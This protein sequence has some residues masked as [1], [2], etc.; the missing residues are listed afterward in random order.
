MS[1]VTPCRL[2]H[3]VGYC[4]LAWKYPCT[5][6]Y[7]ICK[8]PENNH[9]PKD[10]V[11]IVAFPIWN[12]G[13]YNKYCSL[14]L[15]YWGVCL[16]QTTKSAHSRPQNLPRVD[17]KV[18]LEQTAHLPTA[19]RYLGIS[20][21]AN[22]IGTY[23]LCTVMK[24]ICEPPAKGALCT[25]SFKILFYQ[26]ALRLQPGVHSVLCFS[27]HVGPGQVWGAIYIATNWLRIFI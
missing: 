25:L 23:N 18:C 9:K 15:S 19:D 10:I 2:H 6:F 21:I 16:Q 13:L 14:L 8:P 26:F 20:S 24:V 3:G 27:F 11:T 5:I 12:C 4:L 1:E 17:C 22:H 7:L